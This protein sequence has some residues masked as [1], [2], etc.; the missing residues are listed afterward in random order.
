MK[1][2]SDKASIYYMNVQVAFKKK[3]VVSE[4]SLWIVSVHDTPYDIMK[5]DKRATIM[6]INKIYGVKSKDKNKDIIIRKILSKKFI[7][8]SNLTIDEFKR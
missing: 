7:N 2:R 4:R 8:Y 3:K 1:C 6:L 5:Y